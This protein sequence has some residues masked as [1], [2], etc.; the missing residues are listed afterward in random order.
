MGFLETLPP[1]AVDQLQAAASRRAYEA[2]AALFHARQPPDRVWILLSGRVK[3]NRITED[4]REVVLAVREPGDL[5]G[6]MAAID[7]EPRSAGAVALEPVEALVLSAQDF[8]GLIDRVPGVARAVLRLMTSRLRDADRKRVE[9]LA[10]DTVGRVASR[11]VELAERF[12]ETAGG[13]VRID[14]PLTQEDLAAWSGSSREAT[15]K[16]LRSL[17]E[18]G[19]IETARREI[20]VLDLDCLRRRSL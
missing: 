18:L 15:I 13:E 11:L 7:G 8:A 20:T 5:I 19:W 14:L 6:E 9:F 3:L 2:G 17:R 4:G 1:D 10:M 12:G 16:A